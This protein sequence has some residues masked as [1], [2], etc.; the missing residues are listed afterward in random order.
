MPA[1]AAHLPCRHVYR[2]T[3]D[4]MPRWLRRLWVWL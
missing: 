3:A 1:H 4:R 2:P